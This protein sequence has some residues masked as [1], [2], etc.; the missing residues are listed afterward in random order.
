V[1]V[2]FCFFVCLCVYLFVGGWGRG[3]GV[4]MM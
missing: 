3:E 2:F 1:L 4:R